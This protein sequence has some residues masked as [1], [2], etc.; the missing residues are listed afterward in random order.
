[1]SSSVNSENCSHAVE[2]EC[3]SVKEPLQWGRVGGHHKGLITV[4]GFW[5]KRLNNAGFSLGNKNV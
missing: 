1:M 5:F 2:Q 3:N 4:L